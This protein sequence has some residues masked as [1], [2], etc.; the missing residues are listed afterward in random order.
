MQNST[1]AHFQNEGLHFFNILT[2]I[3][4]FFYICHIKCLDCKNFRLFLPF[5]I[6]CLEINF[7]CV[8]F[9]YFFKFKE[10]LN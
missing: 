2:Y 4:D 5:F 8:K 3:M 10:G 9:R 7:S 6:G 1:F